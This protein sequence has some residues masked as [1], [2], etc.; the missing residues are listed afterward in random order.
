MRKT[1][2][3][4]ASV[5]MAV[6]VACSKEPVG[7]G[8][9]ATAMPSIHTDQRVY[10]STLREN[11]VNTYHARVNACRD[12][13]IPVQELSVEEADMLGTTRFQRWIEHDRAAYRWEEFYF[14]AGPA[15]PGI[16]CNFYLTSLGTHFYFDSSGVERIDLETNR[17]F[18]GTLDSNLRH[19][20]DRK[21]L[22]E[23]VD[24]LSLGVMDTVQG[25]QCVR[26]S[27]KRLIGNGTAC[28]WADGQQWMFSVGDWGF[29]SSS[30]S[31]GGR[32]NS[33]VLEQ[34]PDPSGHAS[35]EHVETL[36]FDIGTL[37]DPNAMKPRPASAWPAHTP[38]S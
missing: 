8:K 24:P 6:V 14:G 26:H 2:M 3:I 11:A 16:R 34:T 12:A 15:G 27:V 31:A 13:G 18:E 28:T 19:L 36:R 10:L 35:I 30:S 23:Q 17:F 9:E 21:P 37:L 7:A 4:V 20:L 38:R 1:L 5:T 29:S 22:P 25:Q 32:L 33:I